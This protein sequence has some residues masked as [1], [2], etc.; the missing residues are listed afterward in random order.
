MPPWSGLREAC[1]FKRGR[2]LRATKTRPTKLPSAPT[3]ATPTATTITIAEPRWRRLRASGAAFGRLFGLEVFGLE[4]RLAIE[5]AYL[6]VIFGV[7]FGPRQLLR[8]PMLGIGAPGAQPFLMLEF[9]DGDAFA[10]V[11][12][13]PLVRDVA[14]HGRGDGG[15][16]FHE[17]DVSSRTPGRK[18]ERKTVTIM[19]AVL[20]RAKGSIDPF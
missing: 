12:E 16:L 13:K 20:L 6:H 1:A 4:F 7:I 19:A 17:R 15:D 10:V 5:P 18:R 14:R 9:D 3:G 11:R 2:R 8:R